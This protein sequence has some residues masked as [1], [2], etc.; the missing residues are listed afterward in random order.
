[1]SDTFQHFL[2]CT[3]VLQCYRTTAGGYAITSFTII[4]IVFLLPLYIFILYL[5]FKQS[6]KTMAM[7]HCDLFTYHMVLVELLN[8]SASACV[9]YGIQTN[10]V[11]II[12]IGDGMFLIS[13]SGQLFF[14]TMAC[15]ERYL[16]VVHAVA[17]LRLK[18][19]K[20]IRARNLAIAS[21]W[22]FYVLMIG[23]A[24]LHDVE[25]YT[26]RYSLTVV[27]LVLNL[28]FSLCIIRTLI[29]SRPGEGNE[30][31]PRVDQSKLKVIYLI[32]CVQTVLMLRL[33]WTAIMGLLFFLKKEY[34][35]CVLLFL[36]TYWMR[37]PSSLMLPLLYLKRHN[38][39]FWK[40]KN[41]PN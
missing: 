11:Y 20:W 5:G 24:F 41:Q 28:L 16:A 6:F 37:L 26:F 9:C 34:G 22:L 36:F 3:Y 32:A 35:Q 7:N 15:L 39:L 8:V 21:F 12:W 30:R 1:M 33:S 29:C 23:T 19:E 40:K 2:H 25:N 17:Y 38:K 4:S 14:H 13:G 27:Q 31:R 10:N 18:E